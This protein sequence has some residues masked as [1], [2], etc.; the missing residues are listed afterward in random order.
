MKNLAVSL[1]FLLVFTAILGLGYPLAV[2]LV[3]Q[4]AFP[5]QANGSLVVQTG[6][7][8]GSDL[9]GQDFSGKPGYFQGRLSATGDRPYNPL[10]SGGSNLSPAG[11]PFRNRVKASVQAWSERARAAQV[12]SPVPQELV[13]ASASGLD[14]HLSL[15]AVLWQ[16]PIVARERQVPEGG[17][18]TLA[19]KLAQK[20]AFPWDPPT[21]VNLAA[22]NRAVD[23]EFP[24]K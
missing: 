15:E 3:G 20:P 22:L 18:R 8:V 1:R 12:T 16:V 9:I 2:Y 19:E 21:L 5:A 6:K 10:A 7:P 14:P 23:A 4:G 13:T 24:L 11:E 17:L